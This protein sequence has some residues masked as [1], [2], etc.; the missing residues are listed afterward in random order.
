MHCL[1]YNIFFYPSNKTRTREYIEGKKQQEMM[2]IY[3]Y[4][5]LIESKLYMVENLT[6]TTFNKYFSNI[7]HDIIKII[8]VDNISYHS[9][10]MGTQT[11]RLSDLKLT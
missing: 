10:T 2:F 6:K 5:V 1:N 11:S 3:N 8:I 7:D 9:N 4:V